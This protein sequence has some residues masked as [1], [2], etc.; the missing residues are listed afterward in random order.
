MIHGEQDEPEEQGLTDDRDA[1]IE[2]TTTPDSQELSPQQS[3][4]VSSATSRTRQLPR[5]SLG[6]SPSV[7]RPPATEQYYPQTHHFGND[8][9]SPDTHGNSSNGPATGSFYSP[10]MSTLPPQTP[11]SIVSQSPHWPLVDENEV[12]LLRHFVVK[13]SLWVC[14]LFSASLPYTQC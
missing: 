14:I 9:S 2:P 4:T 5:S 8:T 12:T 7:A 3:P 11:V 1:S 6:Q 10:C 13:L